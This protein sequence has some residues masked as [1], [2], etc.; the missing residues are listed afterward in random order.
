L[1]DVFKIHPRGLIPIVALTLTSFSWKQLEHLT[2]PVGVSSMRRKENAIS[3]QWWEESM[4][5]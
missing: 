5:K 4:V 2:H 3:G 1:V